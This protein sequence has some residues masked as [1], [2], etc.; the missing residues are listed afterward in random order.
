MGKKHV[1]S[2][3]TEALFLYEKF[4]H[5]TLCG[6][7]GFFRQKYVKHLDTY[8]CTPVVFWTKPCS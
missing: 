8:K 4:T 5:T 6:T 3:P 1:P 7:N 2:H